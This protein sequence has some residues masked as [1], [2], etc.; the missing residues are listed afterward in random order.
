MARH[1][2]VQ[3]ATTAGDT[4]TLVAAAGGRFALLERDVLSL[5]DWAAYQKADPQ[6]RNNIH[7]PVP[8][9]SSVSARFF[10]EAEFEGTDYFT[11]VDGDTAALTGL[12]LAAGKFAIADVTVPDA[13][14]VVE[15]P[16]A[17]LA[18]K[19]DPVDAASFRWIVEVIS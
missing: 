10:F 19:V 14:Q 9:G 6:W 5:E 8:V 2:L 4:N 17:R 7:A 18:R 13:G 1:S 11:G 16:Q 15:I 3:L 12:K